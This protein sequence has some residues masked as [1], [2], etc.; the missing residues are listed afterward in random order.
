MKLYKGTWEI[1]GSTLK[2]ENPQPRFRAKMGNMHCTEDGTL[3]PEEHIGYGVACNER[4]LPYRMQDRYDRA[5][6]NITLE[7]IV[8]EN[9]HLRAVFLPG[10]GG[11][12]WSLYSKDEER[13]L[14]FV[15]PVFRFANLA[16]R[17]AWMSGGIEWN[18]GHM[19][20]HAFTSADVYCAKVI[21]SDGEVFLRMYDYEAAH[22][23]ILQMDFHLPDGEKQL[24]MHVRIQNARDTDAPL[25]WWTNTA[26]P[27]TE[28]TR[29]F[30]GTPEILFQMTQEEAGH[31]PGFGHCTMPQQPNMPGVDLSY[32]WR[33]PH[34]LEYFF[35]NPKTEA[36]PWEVSIEKDCKGFMERSTQ[37]LRTRKLFCWGSNTGGRHWCDY[38]SK[39][40]CGSYI[41]IQA[42]L[43][44]TQ[45]HTDVIAAD[46]VVSFT[47][48]FG[49]YTADER[50]QELEW[51]E[52][53]PSVA[54]AVEQLLPAAK[55]QKAE[56]E[57][58][59]K[60]TL[61]AQEM[62][63]TGSW[64]G[65]LE[66][67]RRERAG[68]MPIASHLEFPKPQDGEYKVWLEIL[69]GKSMP[70]TRIP[71]P[72][73]TDEKWLGYLEAAARND[74][75]ETMFQYAV[76]LAENGKQKQA[77][78]I[79]AELMARKDPWAAHAMGLL[80]KRDKQ[81]E[82]AAAYFMMAYD[83]EKDTL[84]QSFAEA[85]LQS[86]LTIKAYEKAWE[87]YT[88]IPDEK[89]TETEEL[90]AAEAAVKLGKDAF[91]EE[92]YSKVYSAIREGAVGLSDVWFEHQARKAAREK[93]VQFTPDM[94]DKTLKLPRNL[95]FLM[96]AED[97]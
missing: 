83:W 93:G 9:D 13:E 69:D 88:A 92:A 72:Y 21:A 4:T 3:R 78:E 51:N 66:M 41:E 6:E 90:L 27:L 82:Q 79:F 56:L 14:L 62:L 44:P 75:V 57:Y 91:L 5:E 42:G 29:V 28:H 55:V 16:N 40:G 37:P 12:L 81:F 48:M 85:A 94:V 54:N 10:Y 22:A 95:N 73:L 17:N 20:H 59:S 84:D 86:L 47:Q 45:T 96:F 31:I 89:K 53:L 30:S 70:A 50:A 39:D 18:L 68:E 97:I 26:V 43:A 61:K 46:A 7:T 33:I 74:D 63:H 52:A 34:S 25:Y 23:Q 2:G 87:L 65:G 58:A 76:S 8:M 80:C 38:L 15:N 11:K 77:E 71:H 35:Q 24:A 49:A 64:Y 19:G 1:Q 67:A 60:S 36:S 32:P